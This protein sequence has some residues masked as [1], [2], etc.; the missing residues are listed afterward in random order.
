MKLQQPWLLLDFAGVLG[1]PECR[2]FNPK[3]VSAVTLRGHEMMKHTRDFVEKQ[4]YEAIYG[5]TDSSSSGSSE[6][7]PVSSMF[8]QTTPAKSLGMSTLPRLSVQT[9]S[10][11][12]WQI[13]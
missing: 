13:K 9:L 8:S 12:R 2:F 11:P 5:D 6:L 1:A 4:G 3:L 7:T 10:R